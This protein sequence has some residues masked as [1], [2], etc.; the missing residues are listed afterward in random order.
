MNKIHGK[1]LILTLILSTLLRAQNPYCEYSIE[2]S[3][4]D[5]LIN[6]AFYVTFH[7]LQTEHS[8]VT[9][10]DLKP[11]KSEKY[12]ILLLNEKRYEHD[13][14]N[15]EKTFTFLVFAKQ[16]GVINVRFNFSIR[17][18]SDNAVAQAYVGSRDNVKSIPTQKIEIDAPSIQVVAK[19]SPQEINALGDF[20]L[21]VNIDKNSSNS[22]DTVNVK[23]ILNG[24]GYLN[25]EFEPLEKIEGV[26]I[27]KG[28]SKTKPTPTKNG[29]IYHKEWNYALVSAKSYEIPELSFHLYKPQIQKHETINITKKAIEIIPTDVETLI[30]DKEYPESTNYNEYLSIFYSVLTFLAGFATAFF[31]KFMKCSS[32]PMKEKHDFNALKKSKTPQSALKSLLPIISSKELK[33]DIDKLEAMVYKNRDSS[34]FQKVKENIIAKIINMKK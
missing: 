8:E 18:A 9:F 29:Y 21:S 14:H 23:Y 30:D 20:S 13:Y 27:Y 2:S 25:E 4:K 19:K 12:D 24:V 33:E 7:A 6:E 28:S 26:T 22:Y 31:L 11:I 3:K 34:S 16:S 10:F 32:K 15:A 1:F 17:R 5:V